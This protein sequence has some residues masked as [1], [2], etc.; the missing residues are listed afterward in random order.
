[1]EGEHAQMWQ[2]PCKMTNSSSK[3]LRTLGKLY[4]PRNPKKNPKPAP[5]KILK[6]FHTPI[7]KWLDSDVPNEKII[8]SLTTVD[9]TGKMV[10]WFK[11]RSLRSTAWRGCHSGTGRE[12]ITSW[13]PLSPLTASRTS[14]TAWHGTYNW[15]V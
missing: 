13:T 8:L 3:P 12:T 15:I 5:K 6:L 11:N 4:Q 10:D 14:G 9:L 1:M 7:Q 2:I